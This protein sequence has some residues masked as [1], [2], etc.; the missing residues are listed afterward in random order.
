MVR[1]KLLCMGVTFISQSICRWEQI[2][3]R[4]DVYFC[5]LD[6][7]PPVQNI[8][9]FYA[10][11]PNNVNLIQDMLDLIRKQLIPQLYPL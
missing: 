1:L 2:A 11:N 8:H 5:T 10:E 6:S 4:Y 9:A 7:T 3:S